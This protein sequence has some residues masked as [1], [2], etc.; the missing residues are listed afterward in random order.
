MQMN[1]NVTTTVA[2]LEM[3]NMDSIVFTLSTMLRYVNV[4]FLI[5]VFG[6]FAG[7]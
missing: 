2:K 4:C 1:I 5:H 6:N 3:A 7:F